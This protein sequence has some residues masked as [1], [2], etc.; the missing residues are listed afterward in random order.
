MFFNHTFLLDFNQAN[1]STIS[2]NDSSHVATLFSHELRGWLFL[3]VV[4]FLVGNEAWTRIV[5]FRDKAPVCVSD[6]HFH[7]QLLTRVV[8][9][10][11]CWIIITSWEVGYKYSLLLY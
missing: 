2:S 9:H 11:N 3:F 1:L 6:K 5:I 4:V 10:K 8:E 7:D